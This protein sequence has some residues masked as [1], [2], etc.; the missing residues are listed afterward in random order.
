MQVAE[1]GQQ[2]QVFVAALAEAEAGIEQQRFGC[3]A[4]GLGR[5]E[6]LP[7]FIDDERYD[8][9]RVERWQPRPLCW[10]TA[11][12]HQHDTGGWSHLRQ[13]L[14]HGGI[15]Q[16]ARDVIDDVRAR[17]EGRARGCGVVGID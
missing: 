14:G 9:L 8:R 12:V 13:G 3:D 15:P 11:R 7:Q 4:G 2:M 1:V 10:L 17:R 6:P 16:Q 5:R